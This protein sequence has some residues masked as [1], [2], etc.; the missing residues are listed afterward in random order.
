MQIRA[1]SE[2]LPRQPAM[3]IGYTK[4]LAAGMKQ[5]RVKA[6]KNAYGSVPTLG[7]KSA[8]TSAQ[9]QSMRHHQMSGSAS[10]GALRLPAIRQQR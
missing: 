4:E 3:S 7:D 2:A 6:T 5:A 8:L 9:R 1:S 10:E